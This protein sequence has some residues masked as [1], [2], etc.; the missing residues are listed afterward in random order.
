MS[1]RLDEAEVDAFLRD[2]HTIIVTTIGKDGFPHST[3]LWYAYLDGHIY[4]RKLNKSQGA[5]NISRNDHV[6]CLVE[7]GDNWVDLKAVMVRGRAVPVSDEETVA[8]FMAEND[9]KYLD[10]RTARTAMPDRTVQ[11]YGQQRTVYRV[12]PVGKTVSWWNR[13]LRF[14]T[15]PEPTHRG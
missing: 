14:K 2:G 11:H 13:K 7:T 5:L 8:R 3:P 4:F 10:F 15:D 9:R 1:V 6:C 12:D